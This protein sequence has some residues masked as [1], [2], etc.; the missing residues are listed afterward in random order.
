MTQFFFIVNK[1]GDFCV[2]LEEFSCLER[3]VDMLFFF[4]FFFFFCK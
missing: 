3:Y 4:F 2:Q 1:F